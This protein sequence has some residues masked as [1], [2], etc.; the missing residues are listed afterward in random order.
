MLVSLGR[1]WRAG[2]SWLGYKALREW[3]NWAYAQLQPVRVLEIN[4]TRFKAMGSSER[5]VGEEW[6]GIVAM[7]GILFLDS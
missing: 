4:G 7:N 6:H 3:W 5:S 1:L 2:N